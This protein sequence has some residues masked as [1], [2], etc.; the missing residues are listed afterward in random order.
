MN[1]RHLQRQPLPH[2][3]QSQPWV[4]I[5]NRR[6]T[7]LLTV[8][9]LH[10]TVEAWLKNNGAE[11]VKK[12]WKRTNEGWCKLARLL[13][14]RPPPAKHVLNLRWRWRDGGART[15]AVD[16]RSSQ[17]CVGAFLNPRS[18]RTLF[19][20]NA[21]TFQTK[22][23]IFM[24]LGVWKHCTLLLSSSSLFKCCR[25][26][27]DNEL[28]NP[29]FCRWNTGD[30]IRS[31]HLFQHVFYSVRVPQMFYYLNVKWIA[32]SFFFQLT[33]QCYGEL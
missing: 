31:K 9:F 25:I 22:M 16:M 12:K 1:Y 29:L 24:S 5:L 3:P 10:H 33:C 11:F 19:I 27:P 26:K 23:Q 28:V 14:S 4:C 18:C 13:I 7:E 32:G 6:L 20:S 17:P 2:H 8:L 30:P 15:K 21:G